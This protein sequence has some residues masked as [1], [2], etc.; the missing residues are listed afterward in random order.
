MNEV[1]A[2]TLKPRGECGAM[3]R[4]PSSF[5]SLRMGHRTTL[6]RRATRILRTMHGRGDAACRSGRGVG[7]A[8]AV[9]EGVSRVTPAGETGVTHLRRVHHHRSRCTARRRRRG[10]RGAGVRRTCPLRC[11]LSSRERSA[12]RLDE[13]FPF[14]RMAQRAPRL[15]PEAS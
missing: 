10:N 12:V 8:E 9:E 2:R 3:P 15:L 6:A 4:F 5:S 13:P 14:L 7:R 11:M 1:G